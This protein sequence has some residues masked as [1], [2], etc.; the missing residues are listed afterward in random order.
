MPA[1]DDFA[2]LV[3]RSNYGIAVRNDNTLLAVVIGCGGIAYVEGERIALLVK[4]LEV[5]QIGF[6]LPQNIHMVRIDALV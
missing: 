5:N 4:R 6:A 2:T 1:P 3:V